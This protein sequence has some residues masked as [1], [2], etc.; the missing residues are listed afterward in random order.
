MSSGVSGSVPLS[1]SN[2]FSFSVCSLLDHHAS[3][4]LEALSTDPKAVANELRSPV[5]IHI[6]VAKFL[7][8]ASC[9]FGQHH[10]VLQSTSSKN[11]GAE[12]TSVATKIL[13][14]IAVMHF[15]I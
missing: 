13:S 9:Q 11:P 1:L 7:G 2:P 12:A 15:E 8:S 6:N 10:S 5:T 3:I 4:S 14:W